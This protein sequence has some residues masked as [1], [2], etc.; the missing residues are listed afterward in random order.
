MSD[1][2]AWHLHSRYGLTPADVEP[3]E[4]PGFWR[5]RQPCAGVAG[6]CRA[7]IHG[8]LGNQGPMRH[9]IRYFDPNRDE[10]GRFTSPYRTWRRLRQEASGG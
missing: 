8:T 2:F 7:A 10:R 9:T 1:Q 3:D 6:G 5:T 4:V